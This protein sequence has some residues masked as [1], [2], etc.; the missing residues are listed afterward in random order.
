M[1]STSG[2]PNGSKAPRAFRSVRDV[3]RFYLGRDKASQ[4]ADAP[5]DA[6]PKHDALAE[7]L[8]RVKPRS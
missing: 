5:P 3:E 2:T 7:V 8:K 4:E 6:A 1:T